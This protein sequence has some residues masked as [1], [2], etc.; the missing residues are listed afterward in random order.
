MVGFRATFLRNP[1]ADAFGNPNW[2]PSMLVESCEEVSWRSEMLAS[3][4]APV[5]V[6]GYSECTIRVALDN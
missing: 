4:S 2:L 5:S 3:R 1:L 6:F